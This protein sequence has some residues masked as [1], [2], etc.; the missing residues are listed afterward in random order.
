TLLRDYAQTQSETA[1]ATLVERYV[2]LVYS[3]AFRQLRDAHLAEDVTQAVF[4][5]LARKAGRLSR[6]IVLSGWLLK[7]T[8][9]AANAQIRSAI[10][11]AQREQ[12]AYLQSNVNEPSPEIWEQLAPFLDEAMASLAESD[13]NVLAL[14]YFENR[15]A[16]EIAARLNLNQAAAQKR[17]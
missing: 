9:F 7:T 11:R 4:V 2:G 13:R 3:A 8:R 16:Q 17:V 15:S 5:I 14:R 6:D 1:F 12:E 10:R